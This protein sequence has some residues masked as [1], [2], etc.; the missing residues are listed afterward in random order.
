MMFG[1]KIAYH[2]R[3]LLFCRQIKTGSDMR[4]N[5]S[6]TDIGIQPIVRVD[7]VLIFRKE[8]RAFHFAYIMIQ[9]TGTYQLSVCSDSSR[10]IS[11]KR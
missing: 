11:C 7:S 6:S 10:R 3:Q 9:R 4:Y 8:Y 5:L 1:D 2:T